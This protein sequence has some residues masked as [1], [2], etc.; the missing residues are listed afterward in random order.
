MALNSY[1]HRPFCNRIKFLG[2]IRP[3]LG[4]FFSH[5]NLRIDLSKSFHTSFLINT[6]ETLGQYSISKPFPFFI[7]ITILIQATQ[8]CRS[9]YLAVVRWL[10]SYEDKNEYGNKIED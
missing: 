1:S 4:L 5:Q 7:L 8:A 3:E 10:V 9:T 6:I 2:I